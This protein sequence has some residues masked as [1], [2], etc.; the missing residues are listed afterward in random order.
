MAI[1]SAPALDFAQEQ[2]ERVFGSDFFLKPSR[3][4]GALASV[5]VP[6]M[7]MVCSAVANSTGYW[8]AVTFHPTRLFA[9][10]AAIFNHGG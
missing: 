1:F 3:I 2:I 7:A 8:P 10:F 4:R 5:L 9:G 6:W